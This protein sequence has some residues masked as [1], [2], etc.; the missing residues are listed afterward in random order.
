MTV[1]LEKHQIVKKR[2]QEVIQENEKLYLK[3]QQYKYRNLMLSTERNLL[4]EK[5]QSLDS[6]YE[7]S[8]SELDTLI[9]QKKVIETLKTPKTRRVQQVPRDQQNNPILPFHIGVLTLHSLGTISFKPGFHT[10]KYVYPIGFCCSRYNRLISEY[11]SY[12]TPGMITDYT[13][14]ILDGDHPLFQI[15]AKD[16]PENIIVGNSASGAWSQVVKQAGILRNKNTNTVSGP[17]YFGF[18]NP[19]VMSLLQELPEIEQ[20]IGFKPEKVLL[21][22]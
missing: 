17:E 21:I 15:V 9:E 11:H 5:L 16:D 12:K 3:V 14:T 7:S 1:D 13:C 4:L 8:D 22:D 10:D 19:T 2:L 6:Q 18:G 20:L